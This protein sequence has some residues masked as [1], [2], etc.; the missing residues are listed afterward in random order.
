[1][2]YGGEGVDEFTWKQLVQTIEYDEAEV[3]EVVYEGFGATEKV[4][5]FRHHI[6]D[7]IWREGL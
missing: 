6:K 4:D 3:F 2:E 1:M 7:W 5:A